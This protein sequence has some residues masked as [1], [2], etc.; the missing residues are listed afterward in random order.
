MTPDFENLRSSTDA[1]RLESEATRV[2]EIGTRR[3]RDSL[4][5]G[6]SD[7]SREVPPFVL[8]SARAETG[9]LLERQLLISGG[10]EDRRLARSLRDRGSRS[11]FLLVTVFLLVGLGSAAAL[12]V[13]FQEI[14]EDWRSR[15]SAK[16]DEIAGVRADNRD[17][18]RQRTETERRL[19]E[20]SGKL[21]NESSEKHRIAR[22]AETARRELEH[23]RSDLAS[24]RGQMGE[25][26]SLY[27]RLKAERLSELGRFLRASF[28]RPFRGLW[29]MRKAPALSVG[30]IPKTL[31]NDG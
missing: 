16:D 30:P 19:E 8:P 29:S 14:Q 17:L 9:A 11:T 23:T 18:L 20:T 21:K 5:E 28:V 7:D 2:P 13:R 22:E 15:L 4:L 26:Q 1:G 25:L 10:L 24:L 31:P 12:Y 27:R 6:A 3:S